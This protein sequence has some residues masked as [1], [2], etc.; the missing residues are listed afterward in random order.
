MRPWKSATINLGLAAWA[1]LAWWAARPT[2]AGGDTVLKL[3]AD[4]TGNTTTSV[5]SIE[6]CASLAT[7]GTVMVDI[8]VENVTDLLAW[9]MRISY[10]PDVLEVTAAD[11]EMFQAA[12]EGSEVVNLSE[13]T[14]DSDG[15]Y[16]LQSVD[17]A[18]PPVPDSGS[19]VL[20]RLTLKAKGPGISPLEIAK[21][22]LDGDQ[23]FDQGPFLRDVDGEIIGDEDDDTF[24]DGPIGGAEIHVGEGCGGGPVG[25]TGSEDGGVDAWLLIGSAL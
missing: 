4:P 19:G 24:F 6:S 9:D 1:A 16:S 18:D 17:T 13:E 14:P 3:D 21:I 12:N 8:I 2:L 7:G 22:D 15:L 5:V 10:D 23:A 20:G 11:T 25:S